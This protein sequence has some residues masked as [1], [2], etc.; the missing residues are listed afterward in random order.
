MGLNTLSNNLVTLQ[1]KIQNLNTHLMIWML[2]IKIRMIIYH[3]YVS[4]N[5]FIKKRKPE[6]FT[7][8]CELKRG[9]IKS[10]RLN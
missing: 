6:N 3:S 9:Y 8:T 7:L 4:G 1:R 5:D 2:T 10:F